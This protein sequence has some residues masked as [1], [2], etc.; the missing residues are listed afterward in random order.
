MNKLSTWMLENMHKDSGAHFRLT[1]R[2]ECIDGF[3]LSVQ[4]SAGAYCAPRNNEGPWYEVEV[5]FPSATPDIIMSYA[6]Q[7]EIP[8]N[9]VYG[10]VPIELVQ[11]LIDLHGGIKGAV[12]S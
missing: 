5:G 6:E 9:T 2:I 10:Y 3:T 7:P 1:R 12:E 11:R 4:A 8:T